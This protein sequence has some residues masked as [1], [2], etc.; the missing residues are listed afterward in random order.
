M[1]GPNDTPS[2]FHWSLQIMAQAVQFSDQEVNVFVLHSRV[3]D[4]IS[5]EIRDITEWLVADH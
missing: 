2:E 5:E 3:R 1:A 4:D